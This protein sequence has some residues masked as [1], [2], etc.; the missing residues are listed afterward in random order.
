MA[1][2][3]T[4]EWIR[5]GATRLLV[6][7][8]ARRERPERR[9]DGPVRGPGLKAGGTFYNPAM[10]FARDLSVLFTEA[11]MEA[12]AA[13]NTH[14]A[15]VPY[16][17]LDALAA[18]GARIL[19]IAVEARRP[20]GVV[21]EG[22]ACDRDPRVVA[23]LRKNIAGNHAAERVAGMQG[24]MHEVAAG[25]HWDHVDVDPFGSPVPFLDSAV[26]RL[27]RGGTIALTAT[28]TAAL[29]G[30]A[31]AA[32]RRRYD[33]QPWHAAGMHEMALRILAGAAVRTAA[34]HEIALRPVLAHATDHYVRVY[35]EA[36]K[37]AGRADAALDRLGFLVESRDGTRRYGSHADNA[38]P[39]VVRWAGPLWG[40]PLQDPQWVAALH[41]RMAAH[42][43]LDRPAL[44]RFLL[45]AAEESGPA[46][47][48]YEIAEVARANKGGPPRLEDFLARLRE[49]GHRATRLHST[50]TGFRT[51]AE[52][53]QILIGARGMSARA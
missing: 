51:D 27:S 17:Y 43:H 7:M 11:R 38:A 24:D 6:P 34:R 32:C 16:R 4:T 1:K 50:P 47:P 53:Q 2:K 48:V 44:E 28:D 15:L 42:P 26:R 41:G 31:A 35:L 3:P 9:R 37:G 23:L 25:G 33:A 20:P 14:K 12:H 30:A 8:D 45:R 10:R 52:W 29:T 21:F 13:K 19:R 22:V 5:E 49:A 18:T 36:D 46:L 39:D 40:G